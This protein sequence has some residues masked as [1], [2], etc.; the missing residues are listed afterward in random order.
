MKN[1]EEFVLLIPASMLLATVITV[2][3]GYTV[4]PMLVLPMVCTYYLGRIHVYQSLED[5]RQKH[6]EKEKNKRH[7]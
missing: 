4:L 5:I 6:E 3:D 1:I 7:E 2:E